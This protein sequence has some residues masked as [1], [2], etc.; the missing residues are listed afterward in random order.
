M[1]IISSLLVISA[2]LGSFYIW[3]TD[4]LVKVNRITSTIQ[5]WA[6][7]AAL[8]SATV[9]IHNYILTGQQFTNGLRPAL[10][11]QAV[12]GSP[13]TRIHYENRTANAFYGLT[14]CI[15]VFT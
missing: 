6:C 9:V 15:K 1:W 14:I 11:L 4:G 3:T 8:I 13:R 7:A 2:L 10:L 12:E 5:L